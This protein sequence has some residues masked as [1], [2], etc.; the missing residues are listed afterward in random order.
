[1]T[2]LTTC[3]HCNRSFV[4]DTEDAPAQR[5]RT[6]RARSA[7]VVSYYPNCPR[8]RASVELA[9]PVTPAVSRKHRR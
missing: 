5:V 1:M 4:Y 9:N 7:W 3:P 2:R 8:C 6:N